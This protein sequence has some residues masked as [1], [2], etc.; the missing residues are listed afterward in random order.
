MVKDIVHDKLFFGDDALACEK[1]TVNSEINKRFIVDS[2]YTSHML[3]ILR[4]MN[5]KRGVKTVVKIVNNKIIKGSLQAD[6]KGYQKN[7]W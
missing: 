1:K 4:N 7:I 3:N 2:G 5:N 6:W